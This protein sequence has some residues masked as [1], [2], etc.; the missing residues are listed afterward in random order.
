MFTK[1]AALYD[2]IYYWKDYETESGR[3]HEIVQYYKQSSGKD[4]LD[5]ACGTGGHIP[6]LKK[7]YAIEGLDLDAELL[8]VARNHAPELTFHHADM[9]DFRL[10]KRFDVVVCLFSS[11]GYVKTIESMR[12]TVKNF[13]RHIKSGGVVIV[14]PWL[15]PGDL[16]FDAAHATFVDEPKLKI[17][18]MNHTTVEGN[19]STL[20]FH[21][22]V[23]TPHDVSYFTETHELGLFT[24]QEY[25]G[26]FMD[27]GFD[28]HY[29]DKGLLGRGLY[30]GV[31]K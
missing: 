13:A 17:S 5:V 26:A 25:L 28:V 23:G 19:I 15:H 29:D 2:A 9:R 16:R 21:Y 12:H 8:K 30:I 31:H 1:S 3:L 4:L 10:D 20:H 6:Y 7:H 24:H 18:R 27:A 14:E 22:L 11:I